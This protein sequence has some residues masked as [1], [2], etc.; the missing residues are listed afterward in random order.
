MCF[1]VSGRLQKRIYGMLS[2]LKTHRFVG[3]TW[4]KCGCLFTKD[5]QA[6]TMLTYPQGYL[7]IYGFIS[8]T[9]IKR[10]CIQGILTCARL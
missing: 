6:G 3:D 8:Q 1:L 7:C 2:F 9:L 4:V 5:K 10:L